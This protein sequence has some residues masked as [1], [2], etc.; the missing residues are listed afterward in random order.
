MP[1]P[2]R[3]AALIVAIALLA[4]CS[5]SSSTDSSTAD[6]EASLPVADPTTSTVE[7]SPDSVV[8]PESSVVVGGGEITVV[9]VTPSGDTEAQPV[10]VLFLHGAAYTSQTWVANGIL[11]SVAE[12]GH[13]SVAI[14]LPG[15]G[16]SDSVDVDEADFLAAL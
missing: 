16:T 13:R 15:S 11:A 6:Q 14:D 3:V 4:G 1:N 8:Q 9:E 2:S 10:A 5:G 7:G 12:A